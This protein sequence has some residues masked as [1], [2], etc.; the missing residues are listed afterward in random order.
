MQE[1]RVRYAVQIQGNGTLTEVGFR[2]YANGSSCE[3]PSA[4]SADGVSSFS[5]G[6]GSAYISPELNVL[7]YYVVGIDGTIAEMAYDST[8][9]WRSPR[10]I[11][12]TAKAH[13]ASPIAATV[14][15]SEIWVFWFDEE[16]KMR[17][18]SSTYPGTT[19]QTGTPI[20][21]T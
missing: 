21:Q 11:G 4:I 8:S 6:V 14:V 13:P 10:T 16:K 12:A 19:W 7:Q 18:A 9:G 2:C 3:P 1:I 5:A 20:V 15:G 17:T